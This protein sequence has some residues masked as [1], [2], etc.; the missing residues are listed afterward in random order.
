MK[1]IPVSI[2]IEDEDNLPVYGSE[3]AAGA[4]LRAANKEPILIEPQ[5]SALI[6]TGLS[7]ELPE[8]Y[9]LQIRPRSGLALKHQITVLNT[10]GTIDADYRGEVGIILVNHGKE[11]FTVEYGMRVAQGVIAQVLQAE[12]VIET[13]LTTSKR[14][15]GGFGHTGT[16]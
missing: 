2:L 3:F 14:G 13:A 16:H 1:K 4:D 10:P 7:L 15:E 5:S 11:P 6:P 9:E 8:G 12:F